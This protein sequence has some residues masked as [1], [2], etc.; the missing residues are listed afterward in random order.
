MSSVSFEWS[1]S[2][3]DAAGFVMVRCHIAGTEYTTH[4][5][6]MQAKVADSFV[7]AKRDYLDRRVRTVAQAIKIFTPPQ[8]KLLQ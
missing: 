8:G 7:R 5:G 2:D 4:F 3:P 1:I 6:P